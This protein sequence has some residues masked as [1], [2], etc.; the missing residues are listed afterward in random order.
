MRR[1]RNTKIIATLG[2]ASETSNQ[3]ERLFRAG[4]DV[5]RINMSHTAEDKLKELVAAI[6]AL[7]TKVDHP[8]GILVDL[9]GPK[10]RV[11][12]V[13]K[14]APELSEG[15]TLML[16]TDPTPGDGTRVG[17][18]HPEIFK[19]LEPGTDVLIDDGKIRLRIEEKTDDNI[20]TRVLSGGK[21]KS[22]KGI[23]L[24]DVVLPISALTKKD[25]YDLEVALAQDVD[26]IA[27][28]FVQRRQDILDLR[29]KV[30]GAASILAKIEKPAALKEL[31]DIIQE[32]DAIM[33]ARGD[34]GVELP[35][36]QV[37][38]RQM[39][40]I[41][42]ARR[43]G[44][45]VV[46]ATQMLESMIEVPVPT[47]AEVSD[48][49]NAV[50]E[51]TDA[52][53]LSAESAVGDYAEEAVSTMARIARTIES[54]PTFR[55]IIDSQRTD[56]EA[57]TADAITAAAHQSAHTLNAAAIV[58]YTTTGSTALRA[59]RERPDTPILVLTPSPKTGRRLA[60]AWG[61][62][63][64]M[65]HDAQDIDDMVRRAWHFSREQGFANPGQQIVITAGLPVGTPGATNLLR[66]TT[67]RDEHE[68]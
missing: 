47:R 48:V 60:I 59:S 38:G 16:D 19:A 5:F 41:R 64:V 28:S 51:G 14:Q 20:R 1:A 68:S 36:E 50:F 62:T 53:M 43:A 3:I 33:V 54:E 67:V 7:E 17:V 2:P 55:S 29:E 37:P 52:I 10:L 9:Q 8:I 49:A 23:N 30:Q 39:Q 26:W 57:T 35:L 24:P 56:P 63:C 4:A 6:R 15:S 65:T 66:I 45:P 12:E 25:E 21:L 18:P 34:L 58:C 22:R 40:I 46:I 11:G 27:L 61:L 32:A 44:K 13:S 31:D 42:A